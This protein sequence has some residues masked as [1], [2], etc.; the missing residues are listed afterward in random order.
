MV[1]VPA[2]DSDRIETMKRIFLRNIR[3]AI[4]D[5]KPDSGRSRE[6]AMS[7][8]RNGLADLHRMDLI[9]AGKFEVWKYV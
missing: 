5:L 7:M 6:Q 1:K 8:Y 9:E 2:Y 4:Q 3:Q